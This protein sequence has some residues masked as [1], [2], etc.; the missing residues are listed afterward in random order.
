MTIDGHLAGEYVQIAETY[1]EEV[2]SLKKP[3]HIVLR[4]VSTV[5][6]AGRNLL[7]RLAT[8]GCRLHASGTYN[9]YIVQLLQSVGTKPAN[10]IGAGRA[11]GNVTRRKR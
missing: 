1:C 6:E 8:S 7:R 4:D 9:S 3:I 11:A 10:S 5:D 2:I